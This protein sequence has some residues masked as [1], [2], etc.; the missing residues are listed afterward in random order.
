M[1]SLWIPA[2]RFLGALRVARE[3]FILNVQEP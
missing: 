3:G 2:E 1:K